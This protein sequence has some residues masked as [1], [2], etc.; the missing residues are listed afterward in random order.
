MSV[1]K[2][3]AAAAGGPIEEKSRKK[4]K[5]RGGN[6][7]RGQRKPKTITIESYRNKSIELGESEAEGLLPL[8]SRETT[9]LSNTEKSQNL[10]KK[11]PAPSPPQ[12][13]ID[14]KH[15]F[16]GNPFVEV[17]KGIIHMYKNK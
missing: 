12:Q 5:N 14:D 15:F 8:S 3:G 11:Q 6:M 13:Q 1:C 9:P 7:H 2:G 17:T 10:A 16:S 4:S